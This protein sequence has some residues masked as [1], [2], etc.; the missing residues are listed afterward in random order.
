MSE[1][2]IQVKLAAYKGVQ[3]KKREVTVTEGEVLAEMERARSYA[4]TTV[5]K[6]DGSAVM[7]DQAVIDFVG[8]INGE[9][10]EGGDGTDYPLVLGSNT[11]IP[12]FEEQLVGAKVGDTVDVKVPFPENYHAKEYAGKDAIFKVTVKGLRAT[13]VPELTDEVVSKISPCKSVDEFKGYVENE[14]RKFK[15]DQIL[16]EKENQILTSIVEASEID[17]PEELVKER[18]DVL[19]NNLIAQLRN[20]GNT[21]EAYLD[22]N[23]LTEEMFD[24][25]TLNDALNML[26]GQAVL[27]EIAR[28]E[29]F[30]YTQEQ[31]DEALFSMARSYQMTVGELQNMIGENGVKMVGSDLLNQQALR[32]IVENCVEV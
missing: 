15:T 8:Y 31:L 14:I 6:E 16:Q 7:G 25:Y 3:V 2:T 10:F 26:K 27:S 20:G 18:A 4:S 23:N 24:R 22:Y 9:A 28:E 29:G 5:D 11:F 12:G 17:V 21:L 19:K 30:T 32:F 1:K 13:I